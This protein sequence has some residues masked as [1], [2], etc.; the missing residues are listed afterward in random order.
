MN[1]GIN[2]LKGEMNTSLLLRL[3]IFSA[4]RSDSTL[5]H[6]N[7]F[8]IVFKTE[9]EAIWYFTIQHRYKSRCL[10]SGQST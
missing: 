8:G 3:T 6:E 2:V 9:A 4:A 5:C 7:M 1:A 10:F